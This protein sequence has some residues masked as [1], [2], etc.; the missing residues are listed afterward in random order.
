MP[1]HDT[2]QG[3]GAIGELDSLE[4]IRVGQFDKQRR[5]LQYFTVDLVTRAVSRKLFVEEAIITLYISVQ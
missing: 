1:R 5:P 3:K 2:K 4:D